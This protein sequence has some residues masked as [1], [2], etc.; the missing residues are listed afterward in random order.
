MY[1]NVGGLFTEEGVPRWAFG[2]I[3]SPAVK[4]VNIRVGFCTSLNGKNNHYENINFNYNS[5]K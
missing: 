2:A 5:T 3:F 4:L 1:D